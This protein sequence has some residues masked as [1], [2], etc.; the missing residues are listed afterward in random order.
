MGVQTEPTNPQAFSSEADEAKRL[1][2]CIRTLI[3][4]R[5]EG[6]VPYF[7]IGRRILY[8]P[9]DVDRLL[10]DRYRRGAQ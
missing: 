6:K 9:S 10:D 5:N 1:G 2:V 3:N 4:W 8:R 7:K